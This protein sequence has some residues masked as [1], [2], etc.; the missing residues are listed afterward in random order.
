M[1]LAG[2]VLQLRVHIIRR[3][4]QASWGGVGGESHYI[5]VS[6]AAAF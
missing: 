3:A 5:G 6:G 2:K 1:G 4:L